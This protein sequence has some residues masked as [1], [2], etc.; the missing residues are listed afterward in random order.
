[1]PNNQASKLRRWGFTLVVIGFLALLTELFS[2]DSWLW[3]T[4]TILVVILISPASNP[5]RHWL[6]WAIE[7]VV[8]ICILVVVVTGI[9]WLDKTM[10]IKSGL[11]FSAVSLFIG[12][13]LQVWGETTWQGQ[14][15][16]EG[17]KPL[18]ERIKEL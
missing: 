12:I 14:I 18:I 9:I 10:G 17:L 5:Q 13:V 11:L 15:I 4:F 7:F 2:I 6:R 16:Q 3:T 1:M 8:G